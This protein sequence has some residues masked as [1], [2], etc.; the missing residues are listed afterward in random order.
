MYD[1]THSEGR[2]EAGDRPEDAEQRA[3]C[4]VDEDAAKI[5]FLSITLSKQSSYVS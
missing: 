4:R 2:H 5:P 3:H 1:E